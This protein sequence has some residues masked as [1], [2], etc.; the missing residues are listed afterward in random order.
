[1]VNFVT[2]KKTYIHTR[3]HTFIYISTEIA[4]T[5]IAKQKSGAALELRV[6]NDG[7][8]IC[9]SSVYWC[10]FDVQYLLVEQRN[11]IL[12]KLRRP[13]YNNKI[14]KAKENSLS[15]PIV[16]ITTPQ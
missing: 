9:R 15:I 10:Y 7:S 2:E 6:D 13:S 12:T 5:L 16:S 1:M 11:I 4:Q 8:I 3:I 14:E